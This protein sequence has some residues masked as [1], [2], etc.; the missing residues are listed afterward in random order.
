MLEIKKKDVSCVI[1]THNRDEFLKEAIHSVIRQSQPPVEIIV[2]NNLPNQKT[3]QLIEKIGKKSHIP[4]NYFEHYMK[5]KGSISMN[6]AVTK[7]K[8]ELI[9]FLNDDDLWEVDYLKKMLVLIEEKKKEINYSWTSKIRDNQKTP[10]K[11]LRENL[12]MK[13]FLLSNPGCQISNL[14]V[15]KE[16]FIGLGGFDDYVIPSNDKDFLIRALYFG[17]NYG[18]LEENLVIQNKHDNKQITDINKE[19]LIGIKKFFKKHEWI[20]SPI[21]KFKF[22]IKYFKIYFKII[23]QSK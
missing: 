19:F 15:N 4:V 16:I 11:K 10:Y 6:L 23:F 22:W 8:G 20:A 12:K 13:D 18:V 1:A 7:A 14:I 21:L 2:V 3:Q 17:Y 9:A 5:G